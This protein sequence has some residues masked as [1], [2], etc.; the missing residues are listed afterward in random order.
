MNFDP[1]RNPLQNLP[2]MFEITLAT[3]FW[4]LGQ[5]KSAAKTISWTCY[6]QHNHF[7]FPGKIISMNTMAIAYAT[8]IDSSACREYK[9]E[10]SLRIQLKLGWSEGVEAY[11]I[12]GYQFG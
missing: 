5:C 12:G 10:G 2:S 1:T 4:Q 7:F 9:P 8:R 11:W 6:Y 3:L